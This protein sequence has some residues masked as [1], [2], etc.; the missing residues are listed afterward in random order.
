[1]YEKKKKKKKR[2]SIKVN[3]TTVVATSD[4]QI[5]GIYRI[6]T[7]LLSLQGLKFL[8]AQII[9]HTSVTKVGGSHHSYAD[10]A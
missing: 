2:S 6:S 4:L 5:R 7:K 8:L 1:M 9:L 3:D 10:S